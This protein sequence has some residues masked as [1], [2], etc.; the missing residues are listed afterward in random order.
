MLVLPIHSS[1]IHI[2]LAS[3]C[4]EL[5][6]DDPRVLI[7]CLCSQRCSHPSLWTSRTRCF[8][9][10]ETT[11]LARMMLKFSKSKRYVPSEFSTC[12]TK[13]KTFRSTAAVF[14]NSGI[15]ACL[16]TSDSAIYLLRPRPLRLRYCITCSSTLGC[17]SPEI[18]VE[19]SENI[20]ITCI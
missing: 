6:L 2:W 11:W 14:A 3:N 9:P 16:D 18:T 13:P 20:R 4:H 7:P 19:N 12:I 1:H 15:F 8:S 10:R 5:S 17:G